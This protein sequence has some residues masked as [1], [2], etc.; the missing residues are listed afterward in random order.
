MFKAV[1]GHLDVG[2]MAANL[3]QYAD[4][5]HPQLKEYAG[6]MPSITGIGLDQDP[7]AKL[8]RDLARRIDYN[9]ELPSFIYFKHQ[10]GLKEGKK[11]SASEPDTAIFLDDKLPEVERKI[12]KT[13]TGGRDTVKEQKKK[14]GNPDI[15]K[16]YEIQK[17]HNPDDKAVQKIYSDCKKGKLM[18]QGCKK[19]CLTF[20]S[21]FLKKHQ[22]KLNSAS[23]MAKRIVY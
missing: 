16:V 12:G 10:A 13:F 4:I 19:L 1:Y 15:C 2:K 21:S 3:L 23:K 18:C 6:K 17:F 5:L 7:H 9:V 11:M 8:T 20:L 14:G 22:K